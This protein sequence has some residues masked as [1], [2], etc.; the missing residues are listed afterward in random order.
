MARTKL[1]VRLQRE[2]ERRRRIQETQAAQ[3]QQRVEAN[4]L[5]SPKKE[6]A[7]EAPSLE[8]VDGSARDD[9]R[10]FNLGRRL[11]MTWRP[12]RWHSLFPDL[13]RVETRHGRDRLDL[14]EDFFQHLE[15]EE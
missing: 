5:A 11:A 14:E 8:P 15:R 6:Q 13:H 7:R 3:R 4:R 1:Q 10:Q 12:D 2:E 9:Y